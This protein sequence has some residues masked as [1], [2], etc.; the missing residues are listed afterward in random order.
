MSDL[1]RLVD[2]RVRYSEG[3]ARNVLQEIQRSGHPADLFIV[4]N[5]N[6]VGVDNQMRQ[7]LETVKEHGVF[8][9]INALRVEAYNLAAAVD[10]IPQLIS[11]GP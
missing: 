2:W 7:I 10:G 1:P 6:A 9:M 5:S 11:R 3:Y 4:I 8:H